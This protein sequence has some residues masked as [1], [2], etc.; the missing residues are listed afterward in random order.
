MTDKELLECL[1]SDMENALQLTNVPNHYKHNSET[2]RK[3]VMEWR[4]AIEEVQKEN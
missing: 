2:L 4:K 3:F 1:K